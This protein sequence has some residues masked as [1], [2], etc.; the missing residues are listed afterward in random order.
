MQFYISPIVDIK[1]QLSVIPAQIDNS[2]LFPCI[3][4]NQTFSFILQYKE[5]KP[6]ENQDLKNKG[7]TV[8]NKFNNEMNNLSDIYI[9]FSILYTSLEGIRIIRIINKKIK[10]CF[11]TIEYIKN[12]DIESVCCIVIKFLISLLKKDRNPLNA[13]TAYKY[14]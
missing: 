5:L 8:E 9:Q 1:H 12:I 14:K 10:I 11:D 4:L 7:N 3:D 2:L 6:K 13:M